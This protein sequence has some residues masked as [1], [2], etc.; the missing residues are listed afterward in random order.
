MKFIEAFCDKL[1]EVQC[2]YQRETD[3]EGQE[4]MLYGHLSC[5]SV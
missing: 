1:D 4:M 2:R 3:N 5:K